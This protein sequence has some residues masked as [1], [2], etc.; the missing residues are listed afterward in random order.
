MQ[1]ANQSN[2]RQTKSSTLCGSKV[3]FA[4]AA[5]AGAG[6]W[7]SLASAAPLYWDT[8]AASG[9][10]PGDGT[11][12]T[13]ST[14]LW[15]T[16]SGGMALTTWTSGADANFSAAGTDNVALSGTI[17]ANSLAVQGST[18]T[19]T[20][21]TLQIGPGGISSS[22]GS[23]APLT[24]NSAISLNGSQTWATKFNS[25]SKITVA[26]DISEAVTGSVLTVGLL[27]SA[28]GG[29]VALSGNNTYTG[30]TRLN[31]GAITALTL[32]VG[33]DTALGTGGLTLAGGTLAS[34]A[35]VSLANAIIV[36]AAT[37]TNVNF[38]AGNLTLSGNITGS[39]TLNTPNVTN[40]NTLALGGD[41]SGFTGAFNN[42]KG[43]L[44][45]NSAGAGSASTAWNVTGSA[46][47][48]GIIL[49]LGSTG[50]IHLGSLAGTNSFDH[51]V[52]VA[53]ASGSAVY[54]MMVGE[55]NHN[56]SVANEIDEVANA[57]LA[58]TKAGTGTLTL[59]DANNSY[60]GP[61]T[62]T[63][64][65][66]SVAAL[67][68]VGSNSNIGRGVSA[69]NAASMVLEGGTLQYTGAAV[70]TNRLFTLGANGGTLDASGTGAV[71][72]TQSGSV[73]FT[74]AGTR[75]LT[76]TGSNT[77]GNTLTAALGNSG[78]DAT[79]LVKSGDGTWK[80][81]ASN[82]YTGSTTIS[83]GTLA[84][85]SGGG[86]DN[87]SGVALAN[88]GTL[89]LS[90]KA[91]GYSV[92]SLSG[93]G[94]VIVAPDQSVGVLGNL[95]A[96]NQTDALIITGGGLNLGSA[97]DFEINL[98]SGIFDS[99]SI[100]QLLDY[101][102]TNLTVAFSGTTATSQQFHILSFADEQGTPN[103]AFSGLTPSES[104]AFDPATG[105]VTVSVPE[106]ASLALL[107]LG[108]LGLLARR[109]RTKDSEMV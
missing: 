71:N 2:R 83:G 9:L 100:A 8:S 43:S 87:S 63:G 86:I 51:I 68:N 61:T 90:A 69:S 75:T 53:P 4:A 106:P 66:L 29:V 93:Q 97:S 73:A 107:G 98:T 54:T 17:Q 89:D 91:A 30:G 23:A 62:V 96:A 58:L 78:S 5:M 59:T 22:N 104:A 44:Q 19:L 34:T 48:K 37:A 27:P 45:F 21:G 28:T 39:G 57:Q 82:T 13:G 105:I 85:T 74:G 88:A 72:F 24:I 77:G 95:N 64:G 1:C 80:L 33:S 20:G 49:N 31:G 12:D 11:W 102:N 16:S 36:N 81:G 14:P 94:S 84:L 42:G 3:L 25:P 7:A 26:G 38:S 18:V 76:L 46:S 109:R 99:A 92:Q 50:T 35:A 40:T 6:T 108:A 47:S 10:Q 67:A 101:N 103:V 41:N 52:T 65:I 79:S 60:T 70:N 56:S 55:L 15:S 32:Q